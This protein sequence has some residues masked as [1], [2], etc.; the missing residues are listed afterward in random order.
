M[1][2]TD[3]ANV[4]SILLLGLAG[5]KLLCGL[6]SDHVGAKFTTVLCIVCTIAGIILLT[7]VDGY[8]IAVTASIIY[9]IGLVF[10]TVPIPLL[11]SALFGYHPQ[12]SIMGIFMALPSAAAMLSLPIVNSIYDR[13]GSYN[14][15]F[16]V[17]AV[18]CACV[19]GLTVLLFVLADRDRKKY[20]STHSELKAFENADT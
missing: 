2:A 4:Q 13:I 5:S 16:W 14:P 1:N 19:L 8:A 6:L 18:M 3:A 11:S 10:V 9:S 7:F 17:V 12:G 20:E 15:I